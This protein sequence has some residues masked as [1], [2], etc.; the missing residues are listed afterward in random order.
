MKPRESFKA[1]INDVLIFAGFAAILAGPVRLMWRDTLSIWW[2]LMWLPLFCLTR[3]IRRKVQHLAL[4]FLCH[5]SLAL[6]PLGLLPLRT[7]PG[8]MLISLLCLAVITAIFSFYYRFHPLPSPYVLVW[9]GCVA[10]LVCAALTSRF[11]TPE[12][13]GFESVCVVILLCF[14]PLL[15]QMERLD[16]SLLVLESH[17]TSMTKERLLLQN[18]VMSLCYTAMIL[19]GV[20][21][22]PLLAQGAFVR[23]LSW[24]GSKLFN[25]FQFLMGLLPKGTDTP[26]AVVTLA[27]PESATELPF[28]FKNDDGLLARVLAIVWQALSY[29]VVLATV[30]GGLYI[31]VRFILFLYRRF[32]ASRVS[33]GDRIESLGWMGRS[34]Q[35]KRKRRKPGPDF[36]TG[37]ERRVRKLYYRTVRRHSGPLPRPSETPREILDARRDTDGLAELTEEYCKVRYNPPR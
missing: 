5:L 13:M 29:A 23:I 30:V 9:P 26:T 20:C 3:L 28:D 24:I 10:A 6:F 4:F 25:F 19:A 33:E 22:T 14:T 11:P 21:V 32:Q 2:L 12:L 34:A 1:L 17:H 35:N 31:T 7:L 36:G 37:E 27:P 15:R 8:L 16:E 18:N